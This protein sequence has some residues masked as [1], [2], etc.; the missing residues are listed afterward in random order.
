ME[1]L[2]NTFYIYRLTYFK[3]FTEEG[4][5]SKQEVICLFAFLFE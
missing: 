4:N 1:Q 3:E 5:N 2:L